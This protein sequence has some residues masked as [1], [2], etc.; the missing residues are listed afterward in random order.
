MLECVHLFWESEIGFG[1]NEALTT[2]LQI[3]KFCSFLCR[4]NGAINFHL[5]KA[6]FSLT[7]LLLHISA[8]SMKFFVGQ[9]WKFSMFENFATVSEAEVFFQLQKDILWFGLPLASS[10]FSSYILDA[11]LPNN[12]CVHKAAAS[13]FI[14]WGHQ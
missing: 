10:S 7:V 12:V 3:L 6:L 11:R 9:L 14:Y 5:S 13:N 8:C 1:F 2:K 4:I